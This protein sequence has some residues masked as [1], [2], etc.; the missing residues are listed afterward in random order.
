M[1]ERD[2]GSEK[3]SC[4]YWQDACV[5]CA[6]CGLRGFFIEIAGLWEKFDETGN[7]DS[8]AIF[9]FIEEDG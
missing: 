7:L 6:F 1:T 4:H 3:G 5:V 2:R 9:V 8:R